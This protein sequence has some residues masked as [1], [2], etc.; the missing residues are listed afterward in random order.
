MV[1]VLNSAVGRHVLLSKVTFVKGGHVL[2]VWLS[3]CRQAGSVAVG[4]FLGSGLVE[5]DGLAGY[6]PGQFV[7]SFAADVLVRALQRESGPLI[8]VKQRRFP[9]SAVVA[10]RARRDSSLGKLPAVDVL[11]ALLTLRWRRLE[12]HMDQASLLVRWFMAIHAGGGP[13]CTQ[14]GK[15]SLGVIET[16]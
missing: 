10:L 15:R 8:V 6:R 1:T 11:V 7:A 4:A 9:T 12:V 3:L 14:Q 2:Q 16:R 13:M 5:K